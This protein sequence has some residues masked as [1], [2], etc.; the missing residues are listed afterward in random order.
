MIQGIDS[1]DISSCSKMKPASGFD[2]QTH[3]FLVRN[4][5]YD[6][7]TDNTRHNYP[8]QVQFIID[9]SDTDIYNKIEAGQLDMA[10]S[11]IPPQVL[12]KYVTDPS[13]KSR[14]FQNSGDRTWFITM[15]LTQ[16]P[17]DDI[18]VR[19]A[20]N[21][22]MDKYGIRQAW[23]GPTYGKIANHIV[24]DTLFNFQLQEF[25]PYKTPGDRGSVAKAKAAMKGSKYDTNH[26]GMCSAKECKGILLVA[27]AR[28]ADPQVVAVM[29]QSAKKIG[30]TFTVRTINNAY[31][32]IQT[33]AKNVPISERPGWGKDF[34]SAVTFFGPL[35]D[36]RNLIP[37]GNVNYPLVGITPAQCKKFHVTG[38]C[39]KVPTVAPMLDKCVVLFGQAQTACYEGIDKYVMTNVVPWIPWSWSYV[40]RI[41]ST[42]VKHYQFDQFSTTPAYSEIALK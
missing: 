42:N 7:K 2:S 15:N 23:G 27:D 5:N 1:V 41:T 14:F 26:D 19:K 38:N 16:P 11:T 21:W 40:T 22:V 36:G 28:A 34:A 35:F 6:Q 3:I 13:L 29:E 10:V 24:P 30:I 9:S 17:F 20:M 39:T 31:P 32:T 33:V 12:R 4:P 37:T 8:D 18:H 25:A